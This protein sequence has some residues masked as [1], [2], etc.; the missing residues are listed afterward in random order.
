[1]CDINTK[2]EQ[3]VNIYI[4][5]VFSLIGELQVDMDSFLFFFI[6]RHSLKVWLC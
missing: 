5:H 3:F 4:F 2:I 6:I 1:M